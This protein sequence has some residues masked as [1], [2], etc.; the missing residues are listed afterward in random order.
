[1]VSF[2][3]RRS[4]PL[5]W[6][7]PQANLWGLCVFQS[8]KNTLR[9]DLFAQLQVGGAWLK[10]RAPAPLLLIQIITFWWATR[11]FLN[12]QASISKSSVFQ[13]IYEI[14]I[15]PKRHKP[16]SNCWWQ[17]N[18]APS[19]PKSAWLDRPVPL[20]QVVA[21]HKSCSRWTCQFWL[22]RNVRRLCWA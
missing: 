21:S 18:R 19:P 9:L 1:M 2:P 15:L 14:N 4:Q 6:S 11:K 20:F 16:S 17:K 7:F 5:P 8:Q 3:A 12:N 13:Y 10:V 22:R